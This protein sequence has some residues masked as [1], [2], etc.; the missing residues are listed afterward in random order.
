MTV[1]DLAQSTSK[2]VH[3]AVGEAAAGN[4]TESR[5]RVEMGAAESDARVPAQSFDALERLV[6]RKGPGYRD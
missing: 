1:V 2:A 6:D 5:G 4:S 3:I